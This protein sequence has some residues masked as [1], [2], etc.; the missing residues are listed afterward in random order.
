MA[1]G[2]W[3]PDPLGRNELRWFDGNAWTAHVSNAGVSSL[4]ELAK[5]SD[6]VSDVSHAA[7][8]SAGA[9]SA[10]SP[11]SRGNRPR[12]KVL[13]IGAV[14][15]LVLG[16][17]A[18][19]T[20]G[21]DSGC[22]RPD[23]A[24]D[25]AQAEDVAGLLRFQS[26]QEPTR[27]RCEW[28]EIYEPAITFYAVDTSRVDT[29]SYK[30]T[31][32]LDELIASAAIGRMTQPDPAGAVS[33]AI[34]TCRTLRAKGIGAVRQQ[35]VDAFNS[36][37]AL[38]TSVDTAVDFLYGAGVPIL[39]PDQVDAIGQTGT[40]TTGGRTAA[41][42]GEELDSTTSSTD[43]LYPSGSIDDAC[44]AVDSL[45]LDVMTGDR[46]F[47]DGADALDHLAAQIED[48]DL[49]DAIVSV[50]QR[51]RVTPRGEK[52]SMVAIIDICGHPAAPD[53]P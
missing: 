42:S 47:S 15:I 46:S 40:P 22:S 45:L 38:F 31:D 20:N 44:E 26:S 9:G 49:H 27:S 28:I 8:A 24:A 30:T 29:N 13:L 17:V 34:Q 36:G 10:E 25:V 23:G 18:F 16:Y 32:E 41:D 48:V 43:Y 11:P 3:H 14:V 12:R 39:C 1:D 33:L 50:S 5:A 35:L 4:D 19:Q 21:S 7:P 37:Q 52:T 51:M 2:A 53:E 6:A